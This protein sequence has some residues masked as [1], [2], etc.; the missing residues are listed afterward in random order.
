MTDKFST[1]II[2]RPVIAKYIMFAVSVFM[3]VTSILEFI[4]GTYSRAFYDL[5]IAIFA[6]LNT[7][8]CD[9]Y[10]YKLENPDVTLTG[11]YQIGSVK[12]IARSDLEAELYSELYM[13]SAPVEFL[14]YIRKF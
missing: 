4:A 13:D 1:Y 9:S 8:Y 11:L 5:G 2:K 7:I 12:F 3:L 6:I 10:S 14:E